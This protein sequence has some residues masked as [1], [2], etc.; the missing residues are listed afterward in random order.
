MRERWSSEK[1]QRI[2]QRLAQINRP[3]SDKKWASV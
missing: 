3:M 1:Y 2:M